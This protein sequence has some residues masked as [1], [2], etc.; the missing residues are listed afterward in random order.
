[1]KTNV[2]NLPTPTPWPNVNARLLGLG[3]GLPIQP[4]DRLAHFSD[5][6][7]ERFTLEWANGYLAKHVPGPK[8]AI[9]S[10]EDPALSAGITVYG[11]QGF[12]GKQIQDEMWTRDRLRPRASGRRGVRHCT[13]I[14]N[15]TSDIDRASC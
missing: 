6:D 2:S 14:Y 3:A 15:S 5:V 11:I 12:T 7:F 9:Y 10:P 1:M 4:L 8:A 13:H